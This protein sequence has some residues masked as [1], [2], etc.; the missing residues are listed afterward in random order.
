MCPSVLCPGRFVVSRIK[1]LFFSVSDRYHAARLDSHV[2]QIIFG[3]KGTPFT[4]RDV[5][6]RSTAF[7]AMALDSYRH[8]R[9]AAQPG[10]LAVKRITSF[11]GQ[12]GL[13]KIKIYIFIHERI[14]SPLHFHTDFF[15]FHLPW[16]LARHLT[17]FRLDFVPAGA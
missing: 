4:Q 14:L 1:G 3:A 15:F 10:G 8:I 16:R 17:G 9:I 7:I 13:V 12:R 5:V 11:G 6:F 2:L